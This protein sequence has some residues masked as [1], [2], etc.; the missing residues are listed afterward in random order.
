MILAARNTVGD[1]RM[2]FLIR[3]RRSWLRFLDFDHQLRRA[4]YLAMGGQDG[5]RVLA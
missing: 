3:D 4:G 1:A 2:E 5:G